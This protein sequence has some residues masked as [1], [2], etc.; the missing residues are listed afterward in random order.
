MTMNN[1]PSLIFVGQQE[2]KT[3]PPTTAKTLYFR[4]AAEPGEIPEK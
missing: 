1:L 3:P 2:V 4:K